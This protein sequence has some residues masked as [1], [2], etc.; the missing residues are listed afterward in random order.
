MKILCYYLRRCLDVPFLWAIVNKSAV[1]ARH[2][3]TRPWAKMKRKRLKQWSH[4]LWKG[5]IASMHFFFLPK[6]SHT[7]EKFQVVANQQLIRNS[8]LPSSLH[9]KNSPPTSRSQCS[10][11]RN[12]PEHSWGLWGSS[13]NMRRR[14]MKHMDLTV[15]LALVLELEWG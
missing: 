8:L 14:S 11:Y 2:E 12:I 9:P 3:C 6:K 7:T 15:E 10:C 1:T 5:T 4:G 13:A